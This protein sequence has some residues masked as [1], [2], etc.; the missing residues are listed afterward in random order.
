MVVTRQGKPAAVLM[1]LEYFLELQEA[2]KDLLEPGY[3]QKLNRAVDE[4]ASGKGIPAEKVYKEL[5][6]I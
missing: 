5:D 2:M 3:I 6:L 4:M 1:D